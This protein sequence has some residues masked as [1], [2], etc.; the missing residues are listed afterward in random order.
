MPV[1]FFCKRAYVLTKRD[2]KHILER[3]FFVAVGMAVAWGL[4]RYAWIK[5]GFLPQVQNTVIDFGIPMALGFLAT[6]FI[7]H[8]ISSLKNKY[9]NFVWI[10]SMLMFFAIFI[11]VNRFV[12]HRTERVISLT[13]LTSS[14]ISQ[15]DNAD[16]VEVKSLNVDTSLVG[17]SFD[18]SVMS[19]PR[20]GSDISF[21]LYQLCP[22]HGING[23]FVGCCSSQRYTYSLAFER[24]IDERK[25]QFMARYCDNIKRVAPKATFLKVVKPSDNLENYQTIVEDNF[26]YYDGRAVA[27]SRIFEISSRNEI[28]DGGQN[29][30][31]MLA[32]L[33]AGLAI[34][35]IVAVIGGVSEW[36]YEDSV[37][38]SNRY[39]QMAKDFLSYP[40]N[41]FIVLPPLVMVVIF[42]AMLV[43]GYSP[44]ASNSVLLYNWGGATASSVF[45]DH[46]WWRLL[47]SVFLHTGLFHII[48]NLVTYCLMV[49]FM[50]SFLRARNIFFTFLLSGVFSVWVGLY[51]SGGGVVGASGGVF[52][53]MGATITLCLLPHCRH[54]S[55]SK[56]I[57][58]ITSVLMFINLFFSLSGGISFSG[59][60]SG[61]VAGAVIGWLLYRYEH[62]ERMY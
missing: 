38:E 53:L 27:K 4:L 44:E 5:L 59:H 34:I 15:T 55:E 2:M 20:G 54:K 40:E 58:I 9:E 49:S 13:E 45:D 19:K 33:A 60:V 8:D 37:K 23:A 7:R 42:V 17:K 21:Y 18:Y 46:Q 31:I 41:W 14:N 57:L 51:F 30:L 25:A 29:L 26:S 16:Y 3:T 39:V 35:A 48:G 22:L 43:C 61:L 47:V 28:S 10:V 52:G 12:Q 6:F 24:E 50:Q 36:E 1:K 62:R 11:S 56:A 32:A